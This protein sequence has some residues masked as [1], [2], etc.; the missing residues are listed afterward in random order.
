MALG[1]KDNY[2]TATRP[3]TTEDEY[4]DL[5]TSSNA[6]VANFWAAIEEIEPLSTELTFDNGK[7]RLTRTIKLMVD[8]R[9][10]EDVDLDDHL[11]IDSSDR[12]WQVS[13]I[14]ETGWKYS[15]TIIAQIKN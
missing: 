6:V 9:D 11:E 12:V 2:I 1:K 3:V 4:G 14:F 5:T 10:T 8:S 13:E 7:P 15:N